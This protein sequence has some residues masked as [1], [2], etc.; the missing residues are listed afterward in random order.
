M[1]PG[2][3]SDPFGMLYQ[4][5]GK[6]AEWG[7]E[8][9]ATDFQDAVHSTVQLVISAHLE[10]AF[11]DHPVMAGQ[12]CDNQMSELLKKP[13]GDFDSFHGVLLPWMEFVG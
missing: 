13:G 3:L 6:P 5:L 2:L 8:V 12:T 11:E 1:S 4:L 10:V 7:N 9:L